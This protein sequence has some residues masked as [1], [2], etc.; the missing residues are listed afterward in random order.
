[1]GPRKLQ[2]LRDSL[3]RLSYGGPAEQNR[4][5]DLDPS[6]LML[7]EKALRHP[8]QQNFRQQAI[9]QGERQ[10]L[11]QVQ[12]QQMQQAGERMFQQRLFQRLNPRIGTD[13]DTDP[14]ALFQMRL[15]NMMRLRHGQTP[16]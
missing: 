5:D 8:D 7:I 11:Q 14:E 4:L 3:Q 1:M 16:F 13:E 9:L 15:Q 12:S 10:R 2:S 6:N